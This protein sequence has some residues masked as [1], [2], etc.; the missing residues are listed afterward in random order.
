MVSWNDAKI[1]PKKSN[2]INHLGKS[3]KIKDLAAPILAES[4]SPVKQKNSINTILL[5]GFF[6]Q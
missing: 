1:A 6:H 5:I 2:E 3:F 4:L